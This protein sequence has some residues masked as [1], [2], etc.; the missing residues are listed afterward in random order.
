MASLNNSNKF[1]NYLFEGEET[2][3]TSDFSQ[4][5][6]DA[7]SFQ[8]KFQKLRQFDDKIINILNSELPTESFHKDNKKICVQ[9]QGE[10][11]SS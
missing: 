6:G 7:I 9:F 11:N 1:N 3:R 5:C 10:V 2:I 8:S 4:S